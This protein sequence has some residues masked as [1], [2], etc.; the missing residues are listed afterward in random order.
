M[1]LLAYYAGFSFPIALLA[2]IGAYFG[3]WKSADTKLPTGE[4]VSLFFSLW[5]LS[6]VLVLG[7]HL[8]I[9][10]QNESAADLWGPLIAGVLI[11]RFIVNWRCE[12]WSQ[13]STH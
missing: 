12:V 10:P 7:F 11:G 3:V 4:V 1:D 8:V 6:A 9:G 2:F 13:P 5:V